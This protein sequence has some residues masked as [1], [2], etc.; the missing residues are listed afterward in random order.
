[1]Q[2]KYLLLFLLL[3]TTIYQR[4]QAETWDFTDWEKRTTVKKLDNGLTVI[5]VNRKAAPVFSYSLRVNVGSAEEEIGKTGLAHMF[6]H[7]A[8]KGTTTI[9]TKDF[10]KEQGALAKIEKAYQAYEIEQSKEQGTN[11][12][13]LRILK[14]AWKSAM[15]EAETFVVSNEYSKILKNL[16]CPN[17][18]ASTSY[19]KTDYHFSCPVNVFQLWAYLE[20]ERLLHPVFRQFYQERNV[21]MEERG[22]DEDSNP[23]YKLYEQFYAAAFT[24]HPYGHSTIGWR[25]DLE[26][27]STQDALAFYQKY[28]V[29]SNM[30][31]TI[32]GDLE[33]KEVFPLI[34]AYFGRLKD[35]LKP[36]SLPTIE[37][38][39][40][41]ERN[42]ILYHT[43]QPLYVEGYHMP[44]A[45]HPDDPVYVLLADLLASGQTSRLYQTLVQTKKLV[46]SIK[47]WINLP[48]GKYPGLFVISANPSKG[49]LVEEIREALHQE[50]AKLTETLV[51]AEELQ[52]AR[53]REKMDLLLA[54]QNNTGIAKL[55]GEAQQLYGDWHYPFQFLEKIQQV[56]PEDIKRVAQDLFLA[57]N[58]TSAWIQ[59]KKSQSEIKTKKK[60][61]E[62]R[63]T[64]KEAFRK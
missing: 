21:V 46:P 44:N 12:E 14:E 36:P 4:S 64:Q 43:A 9:G 45:H 63:I 47:A 20:S 11:E 18:N 27:L 24:A 41:A 59:D 53:M 26:H 35:R 25:S 57:S 49:H 23:I 37:P 13:K 1:M 51:S 61:P 22:K 7:M 38:K 52:K 58:R 56:K 19:D 50:L 62:T 10:Q 3:S 31:L 60:S 5:L 15:Q 8:F 30:V 29:P 33:A 55:F 40:E 6:E 32:V 2:I 39:Q 54:I 28:Y 34:T 16:G 48:G 17:I 42:V